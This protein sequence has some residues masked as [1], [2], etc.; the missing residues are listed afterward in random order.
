MDQGAEEE[1][2]NVSGTE[3]AEGK[4]EQGGRKGTLDY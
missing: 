2:I 4:G 3:S 1:I